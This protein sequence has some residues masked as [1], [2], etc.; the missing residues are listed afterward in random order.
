MRG[1][2]RNFA[3]KEEIR[4][5]SLSIKKEFHE[6]REEVISRFESNEK[7][8]EFLGQDI[9]ELKVT[10]KNLDTRVGN[11]ERLFY[12]QVVHLNSIRSEFSAQL[13]S[14]K[15]D[16]MKWMFIF[17]TSQLTILLGFLIFR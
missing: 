6:F 9:I 2:L 16:L 12:D 7:K 4:N 10:T 15:S 11:M 17:W 8:I 14:T 1:E 13:A 3:T 5:L